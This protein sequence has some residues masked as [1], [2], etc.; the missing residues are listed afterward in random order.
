LKDKTIILT[1][2]ENSLESLKN[3]LESEG[4]N[5]IHHPMISIAKIDFSLPKQR[6]DWIVFTSRYGVRFFFEGLDSAEID[7]LKAYKTKFACIGIFTAKELIYFGFKADIISSVATSKKLSALLVT[8]IKNGDN[9]LLAL[10][11]LAGNALQDSLNYVEIINRV[12]VY[13]NLPITVSD[14]LKER[15]KQNNFDR[16]V[17][18]S[19]SAVD[20]LHEQTKKYFDNIN[21]KAVVIGSVT[22]NSLKKINIDKMWVANNDRISLL[23]TIINSFEK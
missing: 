6:F 12:D 16:I 23:S 7:S 3:S 14:K 8:K 1:H 15:I 5:V 21:S 2:A 19:P 4:M 17:F 13:N 10:G 9:V 11:K 18:A 20:F 22:A